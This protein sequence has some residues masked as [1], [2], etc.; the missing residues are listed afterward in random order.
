MFENVGNWPLWYWFLAAYTAA[1]SIPRVRVYARQLGPLRAAA[2]SA[3]SDLERGRVRGQQVGGGLR[4]ISW[5]VGGLLLVGGWDWARLAVAIAYARSTMTSFRDYATGFAEGRKAASLAAAPEYVR[6]RVSPRAPD[7]F[8]ATLFAG[9]TRVLPLTLVAV[10]IVRL[11]GGG[12]PWRT[13]G[14][15][16]LSGLGVAVVLIIAVIAWSTYSTRLPPVALRG[17][18]GARVQLDQLLTRGANG[19][20]VEFQVRERPYL[21]LTFT[22]HLSGSSGS[23]FKS[24]STASELR[25]VSTL[26][27]PRSDRDAFRDRVRDLAACDFEM[28]SQQNWRGRL[29]YSVD[30]GRDVAS[31]AA[32]L[33]LVFARIFRVDQDCDVIA[34]SKVL[35][36]SNAPHLTGVDSPEV[37]HEP[38][39]T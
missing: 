18:A 23:L 39:A 19:A 12:I 11:P 1:L 3:P 17:V 2:R 29:V 27:E 4:A 33:D 13:L 9:L 31:A 26:A 35:V 22:K 37:L 24:Y 34:T 38:P 10:A 20:A 25:I 14:V 16:T 15:I 7:Y 28:V 21:K 32:W 5:L 30:H 6:G 8:A 36:Q